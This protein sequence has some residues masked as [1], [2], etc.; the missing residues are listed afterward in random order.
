M[1][2]DDSYHL[3]TLDR[4]RQ[5]VVARTLEFAARLQRGILHTLAP[6]DEA[7]EPVAEEPVAEEPKAE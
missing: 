2:L 6:E 1:V 3:V 5:I 4:Q 7:E